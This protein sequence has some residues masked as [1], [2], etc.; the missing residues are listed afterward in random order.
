MI[1][2]FNTFSFNISEMEPSLSHLSVRI[3]SHL[4]LTFIMNTHTCL[5]IVGHLMDSYI[6]CFSHLIG[7]LSPLL[8]LVRIRVRP[9]IHQSHLL[10]LL[11]C[12]CVCG[13]ILVSPV[14]TVREC[15]PV[16]Y[17]L[18]VSSVMMMLEE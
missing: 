16:L 5:N 18:V 10:Q 4:P 17:L 1:V 7:F 15:L 12:A 13:I 9:N 14:I 11:A 3:L 6:N 8:Q 2:R